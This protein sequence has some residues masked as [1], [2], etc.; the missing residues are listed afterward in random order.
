MG[1]KATIVSQTHRWTPRDN[2]LVTRIL[3]IACES[4]SLIKLAD[5]IRK[6]LWQEGSMLQFEVWKG[7]CSPLKHN[8]CEAV[9]RVKGTKIFVAFAKDKQGDTTLVYT[10]PLPIRA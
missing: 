5:R 8:A 1:Q 10:E 7:C 3:Q 2:E 9:Y 6:Q 4:H